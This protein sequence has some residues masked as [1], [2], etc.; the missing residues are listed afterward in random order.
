MEVREA[1]L[2]RCTSG[3][4]WG[5]LSCGDARADGRME[6]WKLGVFPSPNLIPTGIPTCT[7]TSAREAET[8]SPIVSSLVRSPLSLAHGPLDVKWRE[9]TGAVAFVANVNY[10][11][12]TKAPRQ[13]QDGG[14][15]AKS[16][17]CPHI[18]QREMKTNQK[19]PQLKWSLDARWLERQSHGTFLGNGWDLGRHCRL[20]PQQNTACELA[21]GCPVFHK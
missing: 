8:G 13:T 7:Y 1:Q 3:W 12:M 4:R 20:D 6:A 19:Q 10:V 18:Y 21:P 14:H 5:R 9:H 11:L 17:S 16:P 2:W 15:V